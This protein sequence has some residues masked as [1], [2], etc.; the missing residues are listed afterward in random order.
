MKP[1]LL[2]ALAVTITA[3]AIILN[4]SN[5]IEKSFEYYENQ[6]VKRDSIIAAYGE[7]YT[8]TEALLDTISCHYEN[9]LD[10]TA[11]T[12][13]Y[14]FYCIAADRLDSLLVK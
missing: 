6:L 13:V 4:S 7:Y 2:L 8:A 12:D 10:T 5:T 11:E 9:F 1:I 3:L 14:S